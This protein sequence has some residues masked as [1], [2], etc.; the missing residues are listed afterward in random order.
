MNDSRIVTEPDLDLDHR[1]KVLLVDVD[2]TDIEKL[3]KTVE[4]LGIDITLMLYGS[5]DKNDVWCINA[6][7]HAYAT[8][9]NSRFSGNK[10]QLK[11]WLLAQKNCWSLGPNDIAE[12]S[13]RVTYDIY[14]WLVMQHSLYIKEENNV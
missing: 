8:L 4:S 2:W 5:N 7:K 12:Y 9:I 1:F 11:G 3:S 14:S 13:H 6:N 10:E